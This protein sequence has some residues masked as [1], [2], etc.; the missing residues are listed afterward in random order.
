MVWGA[1]SSFVCGEIDVLLNRFQ[2]EDLNCVPKQRV[3]C[4]EV[5][6]CGGKYICSFNRKIELINSY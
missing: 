3:I 5:E 2:M 6:Q 4:F 1:I